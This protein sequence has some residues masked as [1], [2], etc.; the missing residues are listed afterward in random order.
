MANQFLDV[1]QITDTSVMPSLVKDRLET[2]TV[3]EKRYFMSMW[4]KSGVLYITSKPGIA[5]SA[6]A[7]S[8]ASKMGFRY[9]DIRLSMVDETDVGLYPNVSTVDEDGTP[10]KCL[11]FVVPRWAIEANKQPTV[12]HFEE[13]NRA[14][15]PVRN[16]ALQILLERQIGVDFKF[17]NFVLMLASGNL[18]DEDGTDVEEFDNALN[19]RLIHYSHTLSADEWIENF[20]KEKI[21]PVIVSYIKSHPE[22]LYQNPTEN[23]KAY[24]TPRSWH[25]LSD[26]IVSNFGMNAS[27]REFLTTLQELSMSYIGNGAQRFL[28]YCQDMINIS[29]KDIMDNYEKVEKDLDKYNRDKNSELIQSL[30]E[31][32]LKKL[33][34]K[35]LANITKFL[36]RVGDDELTAY[37]LHILDNVS[38][39]TDAKIKKFLQEFKDV[40]LSIKRINK[41]DKK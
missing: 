25:F 24:A 15:L 7:R 30:K 31:Y 18:G 8:I 6:I 9:M 32:D 35:Q 3:R 38:D 22:K 2:L 26:F 23:S 12:I 17:N 21:H 36:K 16:A 19:N 41:P 5:K 14:S 37:L 33:T 13:L 11:D 10:V 20:A 39:V 28:Q 1:S 29:I 27:P 40:L 34:E 4:P